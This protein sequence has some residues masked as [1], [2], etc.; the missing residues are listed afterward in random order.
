MKKSVDV[1][2]LLDE[3]E[4]RAESLLHQFGMETPPFLAARVAAQLKIDIQIASFKDDYSGALFHDAEKGRWI[5]YVNQADPF[6]RR[7][8]TIAHEI[9]HYIFREEFDTEV[10]KDT[11][12]YL[13]YRLM[14]ESL[15]TATPEG[16]K[17]EIV[18]NHFA[19]ALLMP[20]ESFNDTW[21]DLQRINNDGAQVVQS[22]S[23]LYQVSQDA[24]RVRTR[25]LRDK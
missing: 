11:T 6:Y 9:G 17:R 16:I 20:R 21:W 12:G 13:A 24:V 14:G 22:L 3:A 15:N 19:G 10:V 18:V 4:D 5:I 8:F 7:N 25:V 23:K 2:T 1:A